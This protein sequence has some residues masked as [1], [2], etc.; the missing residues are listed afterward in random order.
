MKIFKASALESSHD[1]VP[2]TIESD[3]KT[4]LRVYFR[5]GYVDLLE[6]QIA[7]R[8]KVAIKDFLNGFKLE[9]KWKLQ[10]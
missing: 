2:G 3:N 1:E 10:S 9:G 5:K 6:I 7:G 8:S 4:F